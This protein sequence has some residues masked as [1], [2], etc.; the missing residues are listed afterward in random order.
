MKKRQGLSL[1]ALVLL[2]L[3]PSAAVSAAAPRGTRG[4]M[5]AAPVPRLQVPRLVAALPL[6]ASSGEPRRLGADTCSAAAPDLNVLGLLC[7][8]QFYFDEP[9]GMTTAIKK[10]AAPTQMNGLRLLGCSGAPSSCWPS[11]RTGP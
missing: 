5:L 3:A 4:N 10:Y 2:L 7:D 1:P 6:S 9:M 8:G 11:W